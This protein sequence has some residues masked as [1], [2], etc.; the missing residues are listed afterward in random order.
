MMEPKTLL[1]LSVPSTLG[2]QQL[3]SHS[4]KTKTYSIIPSELYGRARIKNF[5]FSH[6]PVSART[7]LVNDT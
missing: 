2:E 5:L 3:K 1:T 7:T 6:T 4:R